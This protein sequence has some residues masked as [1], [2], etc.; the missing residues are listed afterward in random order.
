MAFSS[1]YYGLIYTFFLVTFALDAVTI[2]VSKALCVT[3]AGA[4]GNRW[5][6]WFA[7]VSEEVSIFIKMQLFQIIIRMI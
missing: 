6:A 3:F 5:C 2:F 4:N 1:S 7:L